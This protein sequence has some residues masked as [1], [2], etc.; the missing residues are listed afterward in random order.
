MSAAV[1]QSAGCNA[2]VTWSVSDATRASVS[3]TGLVTIAANAASGPVAVRATA[4][5]ATGGATANGV[6]TLNVVGTT[7]T[8]V[9]VT[10]GTAEIT[11]GT[12][13]S[14]AQS[15]QLAAS[16]T[17]TNSPA[18]TVSWQSLDQTL[19]TV[20]GTGL[21]T[22][23]SQSKAGAVVIK[24]CSTVNASVCGTASLTVV[25]PN[26]ATISIQSITTGNLA[27]PVTLTNVGGQI[28]ISLNVDNGSFTITKAQALI[29]G[30]VVAE[31]SFAS[32]A[33]GAD[34]PEAV[35]ST[36]VLSTN[37]AQ[38]KKGGTG[39]LFVPVIL[40]GPSAITSRIFVA[41]SSTPISSNA[42]PVVMNN[43][44]AMLTAPTVTLV[45]ASP[46]PSVVNGGV[47]WVKGNA[48]IAGGNYVS[49]APTPANFNWNSNVCAGSSTTG[50]LS[51]N[52]ANG[53]TTAGTFTCGAIEAQV[54]LTGYATL[55][56]TQ[57]AL[58]IP[59]TVAA[60]GYSGVG[61]AYTVDGA[62]RYNLIGAPPAPAPAPTGPFIDNQAPTVTL[63]TVAFN[64][65]FDQQWINASYNFGA[66]A[67]NSS[68]GGSGVASETT[69]AAPNGVAAGVS[70]VNAVNVVSTGADLAETL[71][72]DGTPEGFQICGAATDALGNA[73]AKVGGSNWFGVDKVAPTARYVTSTATAPVGTISG[74]SATA[75]TTIYSMAA[76]HTTTDIFAVEAIDGRSG[77]HQGGAIAGFPV[78]QAQTRFNPANNPAASCAAISSGLPTVLVDTYVRSAEADAN[79]TD[80]AA[81]VPAYY[82]WSA[83]VTD[84]AGNVSTTVSRNFAKDDLAGADITNLAVGQLLY[85]VG[86]SASFNVWGSDDL[87][88]IEGTLALAYNNDNLLAPEFRVRYP[89]ALF[90]IGAR[91]DATLTNAVSGASLTISSLLGRIDS[92]N[93]ADSLPFANAAYNSAGLALPDS[94]YANLRDVASQEDG[95]PLAIGLDSLT[96]FT[97][98]SYGS[99]NAAAWRGTAGVF[100]ATPNRTWSGSTVAGNKLATHLTSTSITEPFFASVNLYGLIGGELVFC[101]TMG[102][103]VMTDNGV[104]R[105]WQYTVATP[106][107]SNACAG[108]GNWYVGGVRGN[109]VLLSVVF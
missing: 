74:V 22:A 73:A 99:G 33:P 87:E 27:T 59:Q 11:A 90:P 3:A 28:E 78:N 105:I 80:N 52:T 56:T 75:N 34:T 70:C 104:F 20:N 12:G 79:C 48:T 96:M 15:V 6:A 72:S 37:T 45:A 25:V 102:T 77:F 93:V 43:T 35:P 81:T 63:N 60:G 101:G 40:N 23:N 30:Q 44:D 24:A 106:T 57:T 5:C 21:V 97:A 84:R 62:N 100:D 86:S 2:A 32:T 89:Y 66:S 14:A 94:V 91:W 7:V 51:G 39:A 98:A 64:T 9:V 42:I 50:T 85:A 17:G 31:Q 47:T 67:V 55:A 16:V 18:Q 88:V 1:T 65:S 10:P 29:G 82:T 83:Y 109:G 13:S 69:Y 49:F 26:P 95:T 4:T 46:S 107:G 92:V 76:P 103:P 71:T 53:Y 36:I 19:A 8:G 41:S 38:L 61:S 108:A 54:A 68:D 58:D